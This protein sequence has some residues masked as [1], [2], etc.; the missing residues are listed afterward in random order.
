M[1]FIRC[2]HYLNLWKD[3]CL[4]RKMQSYVIASLL[5]DRW[6]W[7][8]SLINERSTITMMDHSFYLCNLTIKSLVR[9]LPIHRPPPPY[10]IQHFVSPVGRHNNR[11]RKLSLSASLQTKWRYTPSLCTTFHHI[12]FR[13]LLTALLHLAKPCT[14]LP[15][16]IPAIR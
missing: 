2:A 6:H 8:P 3:V 5:L 11:S 16:A 10:T 12:V 1:I 14:P 13:P 15:T 9:P 4:Q 7:R